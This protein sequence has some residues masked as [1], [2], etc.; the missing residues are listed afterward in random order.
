MKPQDIF[1][2]CESQQDKKEID[3]LDKSVWK[4]NLKFDGERVMSVKKG[5]EVILF[6]RR[7]N[8]ITSK[9]NEVVEAFKKIPFD[10]VID[11]EIID[12]TNNFNLLSRRALT[13][14]K[15]KIKQLETEIPVK[16]MAF[17]IL[18]FGEKGYRLMNEPLHER[19]R[20]LTDIMTFN[21]SKNLEL[22]EYGEID[23]MLSRAVKDNGEGI[24]IKNMNGVYESKR[25]KNW[26]KHKLFKETTITITGFTE[27]NA[28]IR[29]TDKDNFIV[30]QIAGEQS[31]KVKEI[32]N[33]KG[34]CEVYIQY[35]SK[36]Q[37]G[38]FRFPSF[39]GIKDEM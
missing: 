35:L 16:F 19:L 11:G 9:F 24:V 27:N 14:D 39:R 20:V 2:L 28:G 6:N 31:L 13:K 38:K 37:E 33:K 18:S 29:A 21:Q 12:F 23:D 5:T 25:S 10:F 8:I 15:D 17:D 22:V 1:M 7:G 30:C 3:K 32:I 4:G 34:S 26:I 36:S